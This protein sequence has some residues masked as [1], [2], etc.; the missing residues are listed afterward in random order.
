[1]HIILS[2]THDYN[3]ALSALYL[4][5]LNERRIHL[6]R[7]YIARLQNENQPLYCFI[8]PEL[9]KVHNNYHL[10]S[11]A[12]NRLRLICKAKRT[13]DFITLKY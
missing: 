4:T 12:S 8:L 6:C 2:P 13:Q 7:V 10:R 5:T 1:M 3:E 11:G 9:E